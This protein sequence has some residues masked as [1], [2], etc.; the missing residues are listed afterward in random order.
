MEVYANKLN[1]NCIMGKSIDRMDLSALY[2]AL[3]WFE[4]P[5]MHMTS[6]LK[7]LSKMNNPVAGFLESESRSATMSESNIHN[8]LS[9]IIDNVVAS[10]GRVKSFTDELASLI[11]ECSRVHSTTKSLATDMLAFTTFVSVDL[12]II[13]MVADSTSHVIIEFS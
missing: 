8:R 6:N 9:S 4:S 5:L 7:F 3:F 2:R 13:F 1:L 11:A 10:D 12:E